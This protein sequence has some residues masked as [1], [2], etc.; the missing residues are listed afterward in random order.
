[1]KKSKRGENGSAIIEFTIAGIPMIFLLFSTLQLS[2]GIWNV[3]TIDQ[4]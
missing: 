2:L 4:A 1:M 3:F